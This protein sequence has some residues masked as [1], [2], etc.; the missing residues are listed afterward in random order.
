MKRVT[1]TISPKELELQIKLAIWKGLDSYIQQQDI[2][3]CEL[4]KL[5]KTSPASISHLLAGRLTQLS[6]NALISF[7]ANIGLLVDISVMPP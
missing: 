5:L 2:K 3:G 7:A 6:V 1:G 4:A